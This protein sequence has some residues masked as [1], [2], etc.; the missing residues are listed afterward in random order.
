MAVI[1]SASSDRHSFSHS[2]RLLGP[3]VKWLF[4]QISEHALYQVVFG[5]RKCAHL[6]EYANL[7]LLLW[8]AL[9]SRDRT[10]QARWDWRRARLALVLAWL[11]A[12]S[13]E[14]HQAFVPTREATVLDVLIDTSGA[15]LGLGVLWTAGRWR[16]SW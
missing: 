16:G 4:P 2:S 5:V 12:A 6:T 7:G 9:R 14:F 10:G 11:Y 1:F 15:A 13:D 3:V 8:R